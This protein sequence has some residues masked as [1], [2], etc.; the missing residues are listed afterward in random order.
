MANANVSGGE[1]NSTT[2]NADV[3]FIHR[4]MN[5]IPKDE[6]P[7]KV[8]DVEDAGHKDFRSPC[9]KIIFGARSS[10]G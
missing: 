8:E 1:K 7:Y 10:V 4:G 9:S 2:P 5:A 3:F 6:S